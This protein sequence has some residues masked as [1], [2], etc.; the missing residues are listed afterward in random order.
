[1][2]TRLFKA[3]FITIIVLSAAF[4]TLSEHAAESLAAPWFLTGADAMPSFTDFVASLSDGMPGVMRGIYIPTIF[5]YRVIQQPSGKPGYVSTVK[6][7]VTRF[8]MAAQYNVIGIL[9][10]NYLAVDTFSNLK[11]GQEIWVVYGDGKIA[12]Y[13]VASVASYQHYCAN[14]QSILYRGS[15]LAVPDLHRQR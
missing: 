12:Y 10:H 1:M 4:P 7:T 5:S 11:L 14:L 8:G 9:A 6:N 3:F 2:K 15:P 13:I